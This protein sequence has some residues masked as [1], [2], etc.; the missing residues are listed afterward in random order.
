M[1][2]AAMTIECRV[3]DVEEFTAKYRSFSAL[4]TGPGRGLFERIASPEGFFAARTATELGLPA[5]AGVAPLV[6]AERDRVPCSWDRL[7][8]FAGAIVCAVM[9]V[10]G[11]RKTGEKRSV[12]RE[13]FNRAEFYVRAADDAAR[14]AR[15]AALARLVGL[16]DGAGDPGRLRD[17]YGRYLE[18]KYR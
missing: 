13:G 14:P 12:G 1:R 17:D 7:K 3:P 6:E 10:N 5:V 15:E 9:E 18:E 11:Y 4:A 2:T 8:Q 16:L